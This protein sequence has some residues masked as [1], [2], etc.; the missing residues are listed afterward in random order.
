MYRPSI[1]SFWEFWEGWDWI[2]L[3]ERTQFLSRDRFDG[4]EQ[5]QLELNRQQSL[6]LWGE[7]FWVDFWE[8]I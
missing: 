6:G 2:C 3:K 5:L 4:F 7:L 8:P 1:G